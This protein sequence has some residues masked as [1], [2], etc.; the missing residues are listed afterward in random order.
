MENRFEILAKFYGVNEYVIDGIK[1][2]PPTDSKGR[3]IPDRDILMKRFGIG[4]KNFREMVKYTRYTEA[5]YILSAI[6]ATGNAFKGM[7]VLDFG[8]GV[9][10]YAMFFARHGSI[11]TVCDSLNILNFVK[12]RAEQEDLKLE[13]VDREKQEGIFEGKELVIFGEVLE[14]LIDPLAL[15]QICMDA[16]VKYIFSSSYPY[17]KEDY[18]NQPGHIYQAKLLRIPCLDLLT[19]NYNQNTLFRNRNLWSKK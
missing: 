13:Y 11:V 19:A 4:T 6:D 2:I 15:L 8:C 10:D 5:T 7:K 16:G 1:F 3:E 12:F 18:Y 9:A 14:H 17:G